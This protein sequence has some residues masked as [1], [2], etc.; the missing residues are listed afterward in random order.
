MAEHSYSSG[1]SPAPGDDAVTTPNLF[2]NSDL[3]QEDEPSLDQRA[4]LP[5][6]EDGLGQAE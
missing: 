1:R 2:S 4:L 3:K 5:S 6:A